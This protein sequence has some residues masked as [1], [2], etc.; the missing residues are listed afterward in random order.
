MEVALAKDCTDRA[1][2]LRKEAEEH[3]IRCGLVEARI[4]LLKFN[5][6]MQQENPLTKVLFYNEPALQPFEMTPDAVSGLVPTSYEEAFIR[7]YCTDPRKNQAIL[8]EFDKWT[9]EVD[10]K[11]FLGKLT[12]SPKVKPA[13]TSVRSLSPTQLSQVRAQLNERGTDNY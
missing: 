2:G 5:F 12:S 1:K 11:R 3:M 4:C 10:R 6:A 9:K 8:E 7:V 13:E